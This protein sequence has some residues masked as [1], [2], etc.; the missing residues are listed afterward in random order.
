MTPAL[1]TP[2]DDG[3]IPHPIPRPGPEAA[4][5]TQALTFPVELV[6]RAYRRPEAVHRLLA[7]MARDRSGAE[8]GRDVRLNCPIDLLDVPHA[9]MW[10]GP[11]DS[12]VR[13]ATEDLVGMLPLYDPE[14]FRQ[15]VGYVARE[16]TALY[17]RMTAI[18]VASLCDLLREKG[19][20][21][22]SVLELGSLF[23]SFALPLRRL[24]Y[25]VTAVDRYETYGAGLGAY[26]DMLR[27]EGVRVVPTTR[28]NEAERVAGL[29]PHD[30]TIAMAVVEH[31]PHTPRHFLQ[32][33][34][35]STVPGGLLALDTPNVARYWNRWKL[36]RGETVFQDLATQFH[37]D[38]PYEGHH[39]EYTPAEMRWMLEQ[40]GCREVEV[41]LFDYNMLQFQ[42]ID[43]QH[44]D[45]L[46]AVLTD[47]TQ[48]DTIL[49]VGRRD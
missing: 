33:M 47:P 21:S 20:R 11:I 4:V 39:R 16:Q 28:E 44:I 14:V 2:L 10:D 22:G 29:P 26:T 8:L 12:V 24:G 40:V 48:A 7:Q 27:R 3:I 38:I 17:L 42:V 30:C 6:P 5:S 34:V 46:M 35:A 15:N 32:A 1:T 19:F 23:G 18:R 45:C 25:E 9:T 36:T 49:A 43:R 13:T 31:V 41:R 37:C